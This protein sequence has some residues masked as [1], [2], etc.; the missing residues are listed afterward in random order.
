MTE[1]NASVNNKNGKLVLILIALAFIA[2]LLV[3]AWM[4]HIAQRD[5]VW[6]STNHGT[7]IQPPRVLRD[8]LLPT[9]QS[10]VFTL[11]NIK[12]KWSMLYI[13][14][15]PLECDAMCKQAIYHMRQI[16]LALGREMPR[17]QRVLLVGPESVWIEEI[18]AEYPDMHIVF[19]F[20]GANS[21]QQQLVPLQPGIY[22][23][24]PLGNA[25]MVFPPA[26]DP[27]DILKDLKKMLRIS[28]VG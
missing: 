28:K 8:F 18:A 6:H 25:M 14:S 16:R 22:V 23:L 13:P 19:D 15:S 5:G 7:L 4:L 2:P 11:A 21:L 24:D 20:G 26:T 12:G 17:V 3:A 1:K 10:S 9:Y 27:R